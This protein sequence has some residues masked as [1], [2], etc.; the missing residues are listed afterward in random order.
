MSYSRPRSLTCCRW[1]GRRL[2]RLMGYVGTAQTSLWCSNR[3][4][5]L[6]FRRSLEH[7]QRSMSSRS[8]SPEE[9]G[10]PT[11]LGPEGVA[12][13]QAFPLELSAEGDG[14]TGGCSR[15]PRDFKV[16]YESCAPLSDPLLA[17]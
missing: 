14:D 1:S 15:E 3:R 6:S 2:Q 16:V 13:Y 9:S 12:A 7:N 5:S 8:I 4:S 11:A 10:K 17:P